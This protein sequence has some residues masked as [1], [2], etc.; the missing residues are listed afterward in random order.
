[1]KYWPLFLNFALCAGLGC[2]SSSA[3]RNLSHVVDSDLLENFPAEGRRFTFEAENQVIIALDR[4]D[5]ARD[6]LREIRQRINEEERIKAKS[7]KGQTVF[8][9]KLKWLAAIETHR[10]AEVATKDQ[11]VYCA[12]SS[13]ELTKAKLSVRY[14]LPVE[15]DFV[16]PFENQ[17]KSCAE[18]LD[19]RVAK[20]E[21]LKTEAIKEKTKWRNTRSRYARSSG[22][23]NTGL[24]LD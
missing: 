7:K 3:F 11:A 2:S 15:E 21:R 5:F 13:M 20:A 1:M 24:W 19:E 6:E 18:E 23:F 10:K 14:D 16:E 8:E 12:R 17:Y 22:D 9:A 4:L